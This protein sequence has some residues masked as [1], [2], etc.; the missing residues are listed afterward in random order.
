MENIIINNIKNNTI[1]CNGLRRLLPVSKKYPIR[2][3]IEN[4]KVGVIHKF[5]DCGVNLTKVFMNDEGDLKAS[6]TALDYAKY[7]GDQ[8]KAGSSQGNLEKNAQVIAAL[9]QPY[10]Q[11]IIENTI[12]D[13]DCQLANT[14]LISKN[15][16]PIGL[17]IN[18]DKLDIVNKLIN[19]NV[20]LTKVIAKDEG[21]LKASVNALEYALHRRNLLIGFPQNNI[22][23]NNAIISRLTEIPV[24]STP[25]T[26]VNASGSTGANASGSMPT[27]SLGIGGRRKSRKTKS[28]KAKSRKAKS[29]KAK[30]RKAKARKTRRV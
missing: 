11:K 6:M 1:Q 20:D 19:C 18:L 4:D 10:I 9:E 5:A 24:V 8:L 13:A 14:F 29:R 21:D 26:P 7:R 16:Y 23:G 22:D 3:A 27:F 25:P 12:T 30:A 17:A 28:R 2:I 15:I